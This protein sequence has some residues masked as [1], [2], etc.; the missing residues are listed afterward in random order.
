MNRKAIEKYPTEYTLSTSH[1]GGFFITILLFCVICSMWVYCDIQKYIFVLLAMSLLAIAYLYILFQSVEYAIF[2]HKGVLIVRKNRWGKNKEEYYIDWKNVKSIDWTI[3]YSKRARCHII[4][5]SDDY[6]GGYYN[7]TLLPL[8]KFVS[9]AIYYS[10]R[11][12]IVKRNKMFRRKKKMF[13][14]DW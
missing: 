6:Y 11:N 1:I 4:I 5:R 10:G 3:S 12:D 8:K 7:I 13:E 9:L 2:N 14:K